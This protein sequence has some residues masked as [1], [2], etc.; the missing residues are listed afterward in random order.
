MAEPKLRFPARKLA[1]L[2]PG[3]LALLFVVLALV[4]GAFALYGL[5]QSQ[6]STL[7]VLE[8][9]A[10]SL[11]E[12]VSRAE[13]NVLRAEGDMEELVEERLLDNARL[14]AELGPAPAF[15]DTLLERLA[16]DNAL[17]QVDVFDAAGRLVA[18]SGVVDAAALAEWRR[19]LAPLLAGADEALL[20]ELDD[21]LF[22]VAVAV[23]GGGAVIVRAAA[24]RI[25][26][27][28]GRLIQ[29]I[30]ANPDIVYMA[31]QDRLGL[32]A[33][34]HDLVLLESITGDAFLETALTRNAAASRLVEFE[35]EE[36]FEVVIPFAPQGTTLGLL[37]IGLSL[38]ELRAQKQRGRL[39]VALLVLL[40]LILG[41]VG[42]GAVIVRQNLALLSDAYANIQTYSS[43]ILAQ[44]TDAVVATDPAGA[45]EV[46]NQAAEALFGVEGAQ[47]RGQ[48]LRE[49]W[50]H[51]GVD[52][53]L[54][55]EELVGLACRSA[56]ARGRER[57]LSLSS[58]QVYKASGEVETIVLVIQD[59]SEK[60]AMEADLQRRD[61][62][63]S[64]GALASGV[65]HEVRNPLNAISVIVQRLRR[66]FT[67]RTDEGEYGQ[68]TQVV[69]GEVE[70][71]NRII[72]QFLALTRPPAL[73]K[74]RVDL[75]LILARA[76]ETVEPQILAAGLRLERDFAGVGAIQADA[77][78]LHQA[79]LNLLV[80]ALEATAEGHIRLAAQSRPAD[81]VEIEVADTG[82][83][84]PAADAERIFDLYFTTKA[85]GTGLGLSLVHRIV[86][87]HGGRVEV[88]STPGAGTRFVVLLPRGLA[89]AGAAVEV[90]RTA[91]ILRGEQNQ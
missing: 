51:E 81:W 6:Q 77:D 62:L 74:T 60:V 56:D 18:S 17:D 67:P 14:L 83:G 23:R 88:Q 78:Q 79:L 85:A 70:R 4:L 64:M 49:V 1:V 57:A 71:V 16:A 35:G 22:A 5:R 90:G 40:L 30:G 75:A 87:E 58:A 63:A 53:A 32:L 69:A 15:S 41:A 73:A 8:R 68:L 43:R 89:E 21:Q 86:S 76:A 33:A 59:L 3:Y 46:F 11:A 26:S 47:V 7:A 82:S 25:R 9:G 39:Q 72:E 66:E 65:A 37:R 42:T 19:A 50:P 48:N 28:A 12:A 45:I 54:A 80:N 36:L 84:I 55:G 29:E 27:G 44:M 24:E 31:L 52:R 38:D 91:G 34:S 20:F 10:R 13:E 61:R 2:R